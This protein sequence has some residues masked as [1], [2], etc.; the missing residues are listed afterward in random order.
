MSDPLPPVETTPEV[1]NFL[2]SLPLVQNC[3][4]SEHPDDKDNNDWLNGWA[5][6]K[7]L[8]H[9]NVVVAF[10]SYTQ[11]ESK[12]DL[13]RFKE[14]CEEEIEILV[15]CEE[16]SMRSHR[17]KRDWEQECNK[18]VFYDN[19]FISVVKQERQ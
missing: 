3:G 12:A 6:L 15:E 4:F 8:L 13:L 17:P 14:H 10:T 5:G 2:L 1:C 9:P 11:G 16:N 18:D 7:H 19:Y